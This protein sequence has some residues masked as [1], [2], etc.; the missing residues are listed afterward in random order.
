MSYPQYQQQHLPL[1]NLPQQHGGYAPQQEAT[2]GLGSWVLTTFLMFIPLVNIIY[3]LVLAF[4]GSNSLAKRNFA[5]ATLIWMLVS[6]VLAIIVAIVL[7][8]AGVSIFNELSNSYS[9][10]YAY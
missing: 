9:T 5:R 3:L 6:F 2:D 8:T 1:S 7:A 4:G 10:N